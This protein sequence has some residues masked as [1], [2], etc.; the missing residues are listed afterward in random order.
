MKRRTFIRIAAS[1][2]GGI[3]VGLGIPGCGREPP[4]ITRTATGGLALGPWLRIHPDNSATFYAA[5]VEMGQRV[6]AALARILADELDLDWAGL[7]IEQAPQQPAWGKQS[8][9]SS[10]SVRTA[11]EPLRLAAA[12]LRALIVEAAAAELGVDATV[13]QLADS[14]ASDPASGRAIPYVQLG[15]RLLAAKRTP[16]ARPS[17]SG[18]RRLVGRGAATP[19]LRG[20]VDGS[21]RFAGDIQR[22]G[23]LHAVIARPPAIGA[24]L[25]SCDDSRARAVPGFVATLELAPAPAPIGMRGGVAVI[26]RGTWA[27]L[28]ARDALDLRWR[29]PQDP[30]D[31]TTLAAAM[32]ASLDRPGIE[33]LLRE[34]DPDA[35]LAG[36]ARRVEA[37]YELPFLAHMTMEPMNCMARVTGGLCHLEAP[38]QVPDRLAAAVGNYLGIAPADVRIA[39]PPFGGGFGRRVGLDYVIEAVAVARRVD[40]PIKLFWTRED[41]ACN[42]FYRPASSHLLSAAPGVDGRPLAWRHRF[43]STAI[44]AGLEP[45]RRDGFGAGESAGALDLPYRLP[46]RSCEYTLAPST[47]PVG[48][49]RGVAFTANLF[50]IES[51][52]DELALDADADPIDYRLRLLQHPAGETPAPDA[53]ASRLARVLERLRDLLQGE[54][55]GAMLGIACGVVHETCAALALRVAAGAEPALRAAICVADCGIVIDPDGARAQLEGGILHGLSAALGEAASFRGGVQEAG[56]F[57]RYPLLAMRDAR[58][59][60]S[61]ELLESARAPSG[62][63]EISTPLAAPALANALARATGRRQRRL[64][65]RAPA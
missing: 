47:V 37:T 10:R 8:T 9:H 17:P 33:T 38:T 50:A 28:R 48:W 24:V 45:G 3:L 6:H 1:S 41:D 52:I 63:G 21:T 13:L 46:A 22:E 7:R 60:M 34:G 11:W 31:S 61:I 4:A 65:L 14:R 35:V 26:A 59:T 16:P 12:E 36:A 23:M 18:R 55:D 5:R 42:D 19:G 54:P 40:A 15:P 57:D 58:M 39:V 27:A 30:P 53:T 29:L 64:P 20:L 44:A 56:N 49:W 25:E 2:T 32:R 51:F 43:T 62:L